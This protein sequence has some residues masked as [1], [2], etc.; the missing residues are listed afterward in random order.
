MYC[1]TITTV[2]VEYEAVQGGIFDHLIAMLPQ[3][4]LCLYQRSS[5]YGEH[6]GA[7]GAA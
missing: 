4:G 6:Y 3:F 7:A 1:Y 2:W 5:D